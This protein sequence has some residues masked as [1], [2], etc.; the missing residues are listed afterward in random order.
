MGITGFFQA[1]T[2]QPGWRVYSISANGCERVPR[3]IQ[4]LALGY[5]A[6][7]PHDA[8]C[9][10]LCRRLSA[11]QIV[12]WCSRCRQ[13]AC[14]LLALRDYCESLGHKRFESPYLFDR[15]SDGCALASGLVEP[16]VLCGELEWI[17]LGPLQVGLG[18]LVFWTSV[19][20]PSLGLIAHLQKERQKVSNRSRLEWTCLGASRACET[21]FRLSGENRLLNALLPP[22]GI[23]SGLLSL[24]QV[25]K[26]S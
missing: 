2:D 16:I 1:L 7:C 10:L 5:I 24:Y 11:R 20:E 13:M 15:F 4:Y 19:G 18:W 26:E 22:L 8:R 6:V 23:C 21:L 14:P 9:P 17:R 25:I 12:I 3:V